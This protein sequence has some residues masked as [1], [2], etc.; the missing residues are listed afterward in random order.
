MPFGI[1]IVSKLLRNKRFRNNFD[2][3][4]F[5]LRN[6]RLK[7]LLQKGNL[8]IFTLALDKKGPGF[9]HLQ[10]PLFLG[11]LAKLCLPQVFCSSSATCKL[12]ITF[13]ISD[14]CPLYLFSIMAYKPQLSKALQ[15]LIDSK[16]KINLIFFN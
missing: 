5:L 3:P 16:H 6:F 13:E 4:T 15:S 10:V 1:V 11:C 9:F 7:G 14:L 8:S 2:L 12:T